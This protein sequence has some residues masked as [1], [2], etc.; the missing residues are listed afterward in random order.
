M[1]S[2][3]GDAGKE[4]PF[5]ALKPIIILDVVGVCKQ[6]IQGEEGEGIQM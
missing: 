4:S 5:F 2:S 3:E 1:P 6:R